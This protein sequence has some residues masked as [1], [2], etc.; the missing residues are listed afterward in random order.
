MAKIQK[1]I[2]EIYEKDGEYKLAGNY[3]REAAEKYSLEQNRSSDYN[4]CMLKIVDIGIYQA[5]PDYAEL[6]KILET[7]ADKYMQN[8]LTAPSA[9]DLYFKSVLLFL[10]NEDDIGATQALERYINNDPTF[11]Q[12][13]QQKFCKAIIKSVKEQDLG[14]FSDEW[15]IHLNTASNSMKSSHWTSGRPRSSPASRQPS[16]RLRTNNRRSKQPRTSIKETTTTV[17]S[18]DSLI[19]VFYLYYISHVLANIIIF[20]SFLC[21]AKKL[22]ILLQKPI[23]PDMMTKASRI[24]KNS[25]KSWLKKNK[26]AMLAQ[27]Y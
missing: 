1:R 21:T 22:A 12:T 15:Y 9:K 23:A 3:Y 14:L 5:V 4:T 19:L 6:I 13:R 25:Q 18:C 2:A 10:S 17:T 26:T 7:I 8:K 27:T 24:K 16:H 20:T 11:D